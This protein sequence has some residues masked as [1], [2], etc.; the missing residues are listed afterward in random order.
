MCLALAVFENSKKSAETNFCSWYTH[1]NTALEILF[2]L[3][4]CYAGRA[5]NIVLM[6]MFYQTY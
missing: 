4:T 1:N 6:F 2:I 3:I 5:F